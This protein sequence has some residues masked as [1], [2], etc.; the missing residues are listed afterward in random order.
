VAEVGRRQFA[1]P[2]RWF[3]RSGWPRSRATGAGRRRGVID[4]RTRAQGG[5][6]ACVTMMVGLTVKRLTRAAKAHVPKPTRRTACLHVSRAMQAARRRAGLDF[7]S[8]LG[9]RAEAGPRRV[10]PRVRPP[11]LHFSC[12]CELPIDNRPLVRYHSS[13]HCRRRISP[14]ET[15]AWPNVDG[16]RSDDCRVHL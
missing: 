2:F 13:P 8:R 1:G 16:W 4:E 14:C 15:R 11:A 12:G 6:G 3:E 7:T 5:V 10:L 9:R